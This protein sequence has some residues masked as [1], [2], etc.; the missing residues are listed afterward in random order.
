M[1]TNTVHAIKKRFSRDTHMTL[2]GKGVVLGSCNL[3]GPHID[4]RTSRTTRYGHRQG[5]RASVGSEGGEALLLSAT[6]AQWKP[7]AGSVGS[8]VHGNVLSKELLRT[9]M[10]RATTRHSGN[11]DMPP[12]SPSPSLGDYVTKHASNAT[13]PAPLTRSLL[14]LAMCGPLMSNVGSW[15]AY[16]V[17]ST[18]SRAELGTD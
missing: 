6:A 16:N 18:N 4:R 7:A 2:T 14:A 9:W 1:I 10:R 17:N 3:Y 12:K 15:I 13:P 5:T 8:G 11:Q